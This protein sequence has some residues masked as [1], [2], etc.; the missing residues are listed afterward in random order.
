MLQL[1]TGDGDGLLPAPSIMATTKGRHAVRVAWELPRE[2]D[3]Q[4]KLL[5][6][7]VNVVGTKFSSEINSDIR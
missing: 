4:Y 7:V 6:Y 3:P 2:P 1:V 5:L